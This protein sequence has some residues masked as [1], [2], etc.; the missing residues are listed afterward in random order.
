VRVSFRACGLAVNASR[1]VVKDSVNRFYAFC[2][3]V[4]QVWNELAE[5]DVAIES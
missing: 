1:D 3:H 4:G 5:I 2:Y